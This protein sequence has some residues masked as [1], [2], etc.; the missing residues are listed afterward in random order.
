MA[1][2][3]E[4]STEQNTADQRGSRRVIVGNVTSANMEKTC[5]VTVVRRIRDWLSDPAAILQRVGELNYQPLQNPDGQ[6]FGYQ[7]LDVTAAFKDGTGQKTTGDT[8][9]RRQ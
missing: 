1:P 4:Q 7:K 2:S 5:V 3:K 6:D 8:D 9:C